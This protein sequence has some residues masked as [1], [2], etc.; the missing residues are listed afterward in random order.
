MLVEAMEQESISILRV[1]TLE[2]ATELPNDPFLPRGGG[3]KSGL[4][5]ASDGERALRGV[6]LRGVVSLEDGGRSS[7]P[8][9]GRSSPPGQTLW[10]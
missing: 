6:E 7:P 10:A 5:E 4:E 8:G 2:S 9:T 3:T 1:D